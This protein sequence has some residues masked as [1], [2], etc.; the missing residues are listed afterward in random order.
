MGIT[1]PCGDRQH[2]RIH[3]YIAL[4]NP[5]L[6]SLRQNPSPNRNASLRR[7]GDAVFIQQQRHHGAAVAPHQR[8][9]RV[10]HRFLAA[11]GVDQ[12]LAVVG[13]KPPCECLRV[14]AV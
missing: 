3:H 4:F 1:I 6:G 11:D 14:G 8:E 10:H 5:I 13:A 12:R 7:F 2:Q 9:H